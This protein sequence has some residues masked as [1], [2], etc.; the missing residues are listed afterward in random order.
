MVVP[1]TDS[2]KLDSGSGQNKRDSGMRLDIDPDTELPTGQVPP[3]GYPVKAVLRSDAQLGA[4]FDYEG[5]VRASYYGRRVYPSF[6]PSNPRAC[7]VR[8][9]RQFEHAAQHNGLHMKAWAKRLNSCL[10]GRAEDWAFDECPLELP[11]ASWDTRKR[12]FLDWALLPAEQ[13]I[14]RQRLLRF[15]QA[16]ADLSIDFAYTFEEAA[17]GLRDFKEDVWV[18]KCIANLLPPIRSALFELWPEGLPVR[19]R[20]LRDSLYAVDW[21]LYEAA[22]VSLKVVRCGAPFVYEVCSQG[23]T[24]PQQTGSRGSACSSNDRQTPSRPSIALS[25]GATGTSHVYS[26]PA[27]SPSILP[28]RRRRTGVGTTMA[29]TQSRGIATSPAITV[30]H[31]PVSSGVQSNRTSSDVGRGGGAPGMGMYELMSTLSRIPERDRALIMAALE[32]I[33]ISEEEAAQTAAAEN[34]LAS[35]APVKSR[36]RL[37]T[38]SLPAT[39]TSSS[40]AGMAGRPRAAA[41]A[42]IAASAQQCV[43]MDSTTRSVRSPGPHAIEHCS[44]DLATAATAAA[45]RPDTDVRMSES[46]RKQ[47]S[48]SG[49]TGDEH[50]TASDSQQTKGS[51]Q[52]PGHVAELDSAPGTIRL[53][54]RPLTSVPYSRRMSSPILGTSG[55]ADCSDSSGGDVQT[56]A[57]PAS[58]GLQAVSGDV[59]GGSAQ[60][61]R[62]PTA[63]TPNA[64]AAAAAGSG[65]ATRKPQAGKLSG[66]KSDSALTTATRSL[67]AM[68]GRYFRDSVDNA[69]RSPEFTVLQTEF[70]GRNHPHSRRGRFASALL[71]LLHVPSASRLEKDTPA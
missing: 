14:R 10:N 56:A 9:I 32:R 2:P 11:G 62:V 54:T 38:I 24:T 21:S 6:D 18:R 33:G 12:Q 69:L 35:L 26:P 30:S 61:E 57:K 51:A 49:N 34:A 64:I 50:D 31:S 47:S 5:A 71:R 68:E 3:P 25:G 29:A 70:G 28:T 37:A 17:R 67:G 59:Q 4:E 42:T 43:A 13:E 7:P 15:Y 46:S 27:P 16:E 55:D 8:F 58:G 65:S 60:P 22:S 52:A 23:T 45:A 40:A 44:M 20:D 66:R 53:R 48:D 1:C 41:A 39:S 36:S 19:F 63:A